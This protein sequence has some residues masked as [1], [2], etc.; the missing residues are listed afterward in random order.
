MP[1][2]LRRASAVNYD[3]SGRLL[4]I[5]NTLA[6][7]VTG[8]LYVVS[9]TALIMSCEM[10]SPLGW[11]TVTCLSSPP[12]ASRD[13]ALHAPHVIFFVCLPIGRV[14][15]SSFQSSAQLELFV[16]IKGLKWD[17]QVI[18]GTNRL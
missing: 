8:K 16:V 6:N 1:D 7:V 17:N 11:L 13:S 10:V 9:P 12:S 15:H 2:P 18:S 14:L 5:Q 3:A 4:W